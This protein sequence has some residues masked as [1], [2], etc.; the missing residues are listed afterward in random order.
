MFILLLIPDKGTAY[1]KYIVN[2]QFAS[3]KNITGK[4]AKE[5][6]NIT[7]LDNLIE[8]AIDKGEKDVYLPNDTHFG[9][10]GYE[11]TAEAIDKVLAQKGVTE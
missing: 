10:L 5:K 9:T 7:E 1:S 4:L 11:I 2:P 6:I 8:N 3:V